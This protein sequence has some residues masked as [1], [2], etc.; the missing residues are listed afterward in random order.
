MKKSDDRFQDQQA[1]KWLSDRVYR[2][3][4]E[5]QLVKPDDKVLA[6]VSGGADSL[7]L[8]LVLHRLSDLLHIHLSCVHIHHGIRGITADAD[9]DFVRLWCRKLDIP[10]H[11]R[12]ISVPEQAR[13]S[14]TGLE[15]A[16]RD[17]RH[18]IYRGIAQ[19]WACGDQPD[20]S[21]IKVALAHHMD[22]QAETLLLHLGRGAGL[23]GLVGMKPSDGFFIR[24][25]LSCRRDEIEKWLSDQG[26]EWRHDETNDEDFTIRNRLRHQVIPSLS[27]ALRCD[28]I[29]LLY[30]TSKNLAEDR[31]YLESVTR[32]ML[33]QCKK[34][35]RIAV[36]P[37]QA[38]HPA[39]QARVFRQFWRDETDS[40]YELER[41][42]I[43]SI[44]RWL[45]CAKS[46]QGLDLPGYRLVLTRGE[47]RLYRSGKDDNDR[48]MG[49]PKKLIVPGITRIQARG[50][51]IFAKVV[52][53]M[54]SFGYNGAM[55]YFR[56]DRI[57]NC[58]VRTGRPDDRICLKRGNTL[59]LHDFLDQKQVP[60]D[61]RDQV[62]VLAC[63]HDIV[64]IPGY[65]AGK[66]FTASPE[67]SEPGNCIQIRLV[68]D[69]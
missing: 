46:G 2:F 8:L 26:I 30:R 31:D 16:A 64:W 58:E 20:I 42:H 68:H 56:H 35:N 37:F 60:G 52:E 41:V 48:D 18:R 28:A 61:Q 6:S 54:D 24:P 1:S 15:L 59:L 17:A 27:S 39:I 69:A 32:T 66:P 45:P 44:R 34:K 22:D 47:L 53:N 63:G 21:R 57:K 51:T 13:Q 9:S 36:E 43:E 23:D 29:P 25:L 67:N 38:L 4:L 3:I 10:F 49:L 65:G 12:K 19:E 33:S 40:S 5:Q 14:G 11:L 7:A 62:L 55:E 50:V